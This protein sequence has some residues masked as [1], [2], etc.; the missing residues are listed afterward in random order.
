VKVLVAERIA[1]PGIARLRQAA[2]VDDITIANRDA[3]LAIIGDYDALIVRSATQVDA[4][5]LGAAPRLRV[6]G[7]AGTGVDNVDVD[8]ATRHGVLVVNA[9][10]ANAL[11]AAEHTIALMLALARMIPQA[12]AALTAGRWERTRFRGVEICDKTLAILGFGQIGQLV[13]A[14]ARALGMRVVAY[15]PFVSAERIRD[16]GATRSES[17]ADA[18]ADADFVTLHLPATVET[19]GLV[20]VDTI[21]LMRRGVRIINAARGDLIDT[22]ALLAALDAGQVAGAALDVFEQEPLTSSPLFDRD[23]VVVTPHLGASTQEAQDRAGIVIAD[24]VARALSGELVEH[25][26]NLPRISEPE[27]VVLAPFLE[28][29]A[30]LGRVV[31]ALSTGPIDVVDVSF[32]GAIAER[33][34]RLVTLAVLCGALESLEEQSVNLVNALQIAAQ[35]GIEVREGR[36]AAADHANLIR[37]ATSREV[38]IAGTTI[39]RDHRPWLVRALGY[40]VEIELGGRMLFL[41]NADRPGMIGKIGT[42][43]GNAGVNIANM[44]VSRR[45]DGAALTVLRIDG[46]LPAG[47]RGRLDA[48]DG[49]SGLRVVTLPER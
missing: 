45:V 26:V 43:L 13:C 28:L 29:A 10:Q 18:V 39:G 6:V 8:A 47:A 1:D 23:D 35:R 41:R 46:P 30:M 44:N 12:H 31:V 42:A 21:R 7:R 3:L 38:R 37:V 9:P 22:D 24:Q 36:R 27:R 17:V 14:R 33:D 11:S 16:L 32:S 4:E 19:R 25:A 5:L 48:I 2:T 49:L 20:G 34:T 40:D 15:D